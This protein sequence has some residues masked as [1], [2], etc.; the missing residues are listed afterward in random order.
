M[1]P[2]L[3]GQGGLSGKLLQERAQELLE[4]VG[5][6]HRTGHK[7]SEISGG[8]RQRVAVARSLINQPS[9]LLADEP[10]G[11]LDKANSEMLV[12]LIVRLNESRTLTLVLVTHSK[13][14]AKRME[15]AFLL[16]EGGLQKIQP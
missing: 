10:T 15:D 1:I 7:P 14:T 6:G 4:E 5:L 13:E 16:D 9:L 8:E 12:D 3:A 2:A 11:A